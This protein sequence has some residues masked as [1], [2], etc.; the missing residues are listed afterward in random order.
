MIP[1]VK[2]I[3]EIKLHFFKS[4]AQFL[5]TYPQTKAAND[6]E[7][8]IEEP[9]YP[10]YKMG[11]WIAKAGSCKIGFNPNPSNGV[12]IINWKG[13][14]VSVINNRKPKIISCWKKIVNIL[15]ESESFFDLKKKININKLKTNNQSS[16]LPSWLPQVPEIL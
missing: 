16:K 9:T 7:K 2:K 6:D 12:G 10:K 3:H 14:E 11:G 15:N 5:L 13:F 1:N 4:F 8:I